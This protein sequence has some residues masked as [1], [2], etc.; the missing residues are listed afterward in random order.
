MFDDKLAAVE[1]RFKDQIED[2]KE[3]LRLKDENINQLS[4][5]LSIMDEEIKVHKNTEPNM[6]EKWSQFHFEI[7]KVTK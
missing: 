2:V 4:T 5:K 3:M 7:T 1:S 6:I